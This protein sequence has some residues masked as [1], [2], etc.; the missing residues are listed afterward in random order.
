MVVR[1]SVGI[2]F[3]IRRA[4]KE[5]APLV[6]SAMERCANLVG[7]Q[8]GKYADDEDWRKLD[9]AG[10]A[11]VRDNVLTHPVCSMSLI[12]ESA[13][14]GRYRLEYRGGSPEAQ[15]MPSDMCGMTFWFPTEYLEEHG[16]AR[17]RQIAIELLGP[18]PICS[19]IAGLA[20][21]CPIEN[22]IGLRQHMYELCPRYPGI[23]PPDLWR[24]DEMGTKL[25]SPSWMTFLGQPTL[26]EVGGVEGLR[27]RLRS[28]GTTVEDIGGERAVVTLGEWPEAGDNLEGK[29]LPAYRELA[30]VLEPWLY[31][32]KQT[33]S[34]YFHSVEDCRRW[35]RRF[36]E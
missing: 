16:P 14:E 12:D 5:I 36:L 22:L 7:P 26:G 35:M 21:N 31:L 15:F 34:W 19:G 27:A 17:M 4:H 25:P 24:P 32:E 23:N 30:K 13:Q 1:E 8:L 33:S 9:A 6:L 20:Y 28:P 18:L 2:S 3:F 10:W 11:V 29:P